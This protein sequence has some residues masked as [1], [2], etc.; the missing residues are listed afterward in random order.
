MVAWLIV[1]LPAGVASKTYEDD[2]H[3]FC[4]LKKSDTIAAREP[5]I[6]GDAAQNPLLVYMYEALVL[7][8]EQNHKEV[9]LL[10]LA[11]KTVDPGV[12]LKKEPEPTAILPGP[13][14]GGKWFDRGSP[15]DQGE[16]T[17]GW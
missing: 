13:R 4:S 3:S 10:A 5:E 14:G 8:Q 7:E 6:P 9:L 17:R 12:D 1:R 15:V 16:T 11:T 2:P